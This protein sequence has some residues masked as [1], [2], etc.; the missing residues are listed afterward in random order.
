MSN[1]LSYISKTSF[2]AIMSD[3][4]VKVHLGKFLENANSWGTESPDEDVRERALKRVERKKEA[5]VEKGYLSDVTLFVDRASLDER[6]GAAVFKAP[7]NLASELEG[8]YDEHD[9]DKIEAVGTLLKIDGKWQVITSLENVEAIRRKNELSKIKSGKLNIGSFKDE[10]E[11][12]EHLNDN[13]TKNG[14][15]V[16]R[17]HGI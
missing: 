7:E 16:T 1:T 5:I 8:V 14:G 11:Y 6:E 10:L 13:D 17:G 2:G 4:K 15:M 3:E 9:I 12:S